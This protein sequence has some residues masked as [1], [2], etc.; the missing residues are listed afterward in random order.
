MNLLGLA[1]ALH[2]L[3]AR[4]LHTLGHRD[5]GARD[6]IGLIIIG[7]LFQQRRQLRITCT[8]AYLGGGRCGRRWLDSGRLEVAIE[9]QQVGRD[10]CHSL[11][12]LDQ[13]I[14]GQRVV[15]HLGHG[16]HNVPVDPRQGGR[17]DGRQSLLRSALHVRVRAL[18]LGV[19]GA[20]QHQ[21]GLVGADVTI[22]SLKEVF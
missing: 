3:F 5:R 22:V 19:G 18:L 16:A 10:L 2:L 1:A 14:V 9:L 4:R 17:R 15:G 11:A 12:Q 6:D 21:V 8:F 7:Q 13:I 20:R